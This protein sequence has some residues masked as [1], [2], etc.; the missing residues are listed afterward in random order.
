MSG[1]LIGYS[2]IVSA[3]KNSD[4]PTFS[5]TLNFWKRSAL[6][7]LPN[8]FLILI[9]NYILCELNILN[10][11][12]DKFS[13][14]LFATFT[15]NL[16]YPFYGFFWESWSLATQEWFYLLFPLALLALTKVIKLKHSILLISFLFILSAIYYRINAH[17]INYNYFNWDITFR[18]V[19]ASRID[20]IFFGVIAAWFRFYY[21]KIW[22]KNALLLFIIGTV[23][24]FVVSYSPAPLNSI[25]KN[26]IY[27][28]L[29]PIYIMLW[30]PLLDQLKD[31]KTIFGKILSTIS[32]LS[33]AMY[34]LNLLLIQ[35]INNHFS[36]LLKQ[37]TTVKY[38]LYWL[39]TL[40]LSYILYR[41]YENPISRVGNNMLHTTKM[42]YKRIRIKG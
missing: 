26:I 39:L 41:F 18:K 24:F 40:S 1:F 28:S 22:N 19:A 15:Q 35:I 8:Y 34:L 23:V 42:M 10:G 20:C 9:I 4:K 25:Y 38:L 17:G 31:V 29:A 6:R 2:F 36:S 13:F 7:I 12:N 5:K 14:W 21:A 32:V 16:Y 11:S 27:L 37:H 33:Y 30:L 3:N